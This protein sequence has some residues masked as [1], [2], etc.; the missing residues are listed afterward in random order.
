MNNFRS[1]SIAYRETELYDLEIARA[2]HLKKLGEIS[3]FPSNRI[4]NISPVNYSDCRRTGKKFR[5]NGEW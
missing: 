3:T 2:K 1:L 5:L 4:D